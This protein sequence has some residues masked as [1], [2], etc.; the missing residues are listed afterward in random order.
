MDYLENHT[1]SDQT[2]EDQLDIL[3]RFEK[4]DEISVTLKKKGCISGPITSAID[5]ELTEESDQVHV[6]FQNFESE[7][8]DDEAGHHTVSMNR[9]DDGEWEKP[10]LTV[11]TSDMGR[12]RIETVD[13][14]ERVWPSISE[15]ISTTVL[16]RE[17][18][19]ILVMKEIGMT[20]QMI[21]EQWNCDKNTIDMIMAD[22]RQTSKNAE[23]T[24]DRL[25]SSPIDIGGQTYVS[26]V[27]RI[28]E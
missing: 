21:A 4:G 6:Q 12:V 11:S 7:F 27:E 24:I 18:A 1:L 15:V 28:N 3:Q 13:E 16:S 22:I 14:V 23:R 17:E 8:R 10:R 25:E 2:P 20:E 26:L 19:N 9:T 5:N